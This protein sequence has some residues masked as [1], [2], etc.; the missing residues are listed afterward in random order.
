[1]PVHSLSEPDAAGTVA[2][3]TGTD[4]RA[5]RHAMRTIDGNGERTHFSGTGD[6]LWDQAIS[7]PAL[8]PQ[9]GRIAYVTKPKERESEQYRPLVS[10]PLHIWDPAA[11]AARN[12]RPNALGERVAWF[13]DGRRLAYAAPRGNKP[14]TPPEATVH[15]LDTATGEDVALAAGRTPIVSSDGKSVLITRGRDF[16]LVLVDVA[17]RSEQLIR[18]VHGLGTPIALAGSRYLLYTG[19][20]TPGAPAGT[21]TNNSPLVG[22]KAMLAIKLLDLKSGKFV[23]LVPLIDPRRSVSARIAVNPLP[24]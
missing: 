20:T 3:I 24:D 8:A 13:P 19:K 23:T 16:S 18:R 21:T 14:T 6:P 17:T 11:N 10:G 12:V 7:T 15:I 2:F 1:M 9:G 22:A 4:D 5:R